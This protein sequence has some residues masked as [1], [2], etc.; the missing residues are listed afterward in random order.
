MII[1]LQYLRG[2]AALMV[3]YHH[4]AFQLLKQGS[5]LDPPMAGVGAAGVD[6]FFVISGFIMWVTTRDPA[7]TPGAFLH[8]RL[9]RVVP[10]YWGLTLALLGLAA[11]APGLLG[12]TRFDPWHAALSLLFIPVAHPTVIGEI[13]PFFIQGWTLNYEMFF[14]LVFALAM[15]CARR[16]MF[17]AILAV[18]G[19]CVAAGLAFAPEQ[20]ALKFLTSTLL[21]EFAGGMLLGRLYLRWPALAPS[22]AA[23]LLIAGGIALVLTG[24]V[25]VGFGA[26]GARPERALAW[27]LPAMA[28][29]A[30]AV[31]FGG[32][33]ARQGG[34]GARR[35]ILWWL[36]QASYSL[37]L[38]HLFTLSAVALVWK[39]MGWSF[40]AE[41]GAAYVVA[42]LVLSSAVA[43]VVFLCAE[44][45]CMR[46]LR[47][48]RPRAPL[49]VATAPA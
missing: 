17:G 39:R 9:I 21:L 20:P 27:G 19:A 8:R 34:E 25:G 46:W 3:V 49:P 28:I 44:E 7:L 29:V 32:G 37:Y 30:G 31:W 43:V 12:A 14:Y 16:A 1:P 33:A 5:P 35:S 10:L 24:L 26:N 45:P 23:G 15:G 42:A 36:G 6:I 22:I 11:T 4:C 48:A 41:A 2:L 18:L 40:E 13:L 47:R 38:T